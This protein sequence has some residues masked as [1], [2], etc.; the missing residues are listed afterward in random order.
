MRT[1]VRGFPYS[2]TVIADQTDDGTNDQQLEPARNTNTPL[3]S[4]RGFP[5][6]LPPPLGDGHDSPFSG[7]S[8]LRAGSC[9]SFLR[10]ASFRR[11]IF[12]FTDCAESVDSASSQEQKGASKEMITLERKRYEGESEPEPA[13]VGVIASFTEAINLSLGVPPVVPH[14]FF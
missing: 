13:L 6:P 4:K 10:I 1:R 2:A 5:A 7:S 8:F 3:G 12:G 11:V 14:R 9:S